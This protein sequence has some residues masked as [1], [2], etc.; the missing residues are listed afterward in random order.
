MTATSLTPTAVPHERVRT[1]SIVS[2][3]VRKFVRDR[4]LTNSSISMTGC[5]AT[6]DFPGTISR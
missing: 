4:A 2:R 5:F 6:W 1:E 3:L